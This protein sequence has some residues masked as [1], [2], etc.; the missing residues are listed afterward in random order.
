MLGCEMN[1]IY[2]AGD[3]LTPLCGCVIM[4]TGIVDRYSS[5]TNTTTSSAASR[6]MKPITPLSAQFNDNM[7]AINCNINCARISL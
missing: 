2:G 7:Y 5:K 4:M 6:G 1:V 3:M